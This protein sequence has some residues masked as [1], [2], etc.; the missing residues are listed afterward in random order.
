MDKLEEKMVRIE[1]RDSRSILE[2]LRLYK[3]G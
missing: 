2:Q 1:G 3:R